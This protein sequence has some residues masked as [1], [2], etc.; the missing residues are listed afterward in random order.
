MVWEGGER[1]P[2]PYPIAAAVGRSS[3]LRR[4]IR[5]ASPGIL[6]PNALPRSVPGYLHRGAGARPARPPAG[7]GGRG[8]GTL[9]CRSP[10]RSPPDPVARR[11]SPAGR[12]RCDGRDRGDG[13]RGHRGRDRRPDGGSRICRGRPAGRAQ[14]EASPRASEGRGGGRR[15]P[16]PPRPQPRGSQAARRRLPHAR[17]SLLPVAAQSPQRVLPLDRGVLSQR[18]GPAPRTRA[19]ARRRAARS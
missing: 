17:G 19:T 1:K 11:D 9:G 14:V 15:V 3:V 2:A 8:D 16:D 12:R 18:R 13:R 4:T 5:R 7:G 10:R 6:R